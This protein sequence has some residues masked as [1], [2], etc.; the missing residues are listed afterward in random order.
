MHERSS[1]LHPLFINEKLQVM[2]FNA[3]LQT[4]ETYGY[5]FSHVNLAT[6]VYRSVKD[7]V[8]RKDLD[9]LKGDERFHHML[10]LVADNISRLDIQSLSN[11]AYAL[12][13]LNVMEGTTPL[14]LLLAEEILSVHDQNINPIDLSQ[15][16][17]SFCHMACTSSTINDS[18]TIER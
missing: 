9:S 14:I 17:I 15:L 13:K 7:A 3:I 12:Q 1:P 10:A 2:N 5:K 8:I 11:I 18:P 6:A 16:A 4:F